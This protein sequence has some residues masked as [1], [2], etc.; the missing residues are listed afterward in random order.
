MIG[1]KSRLFSPILI[2]VGAAIQC[3]HSRRWV[4]MGLRRVGA[5]FLVFLTVIA[6]CGAETSKAV[7]PSFA[8]TP[9]RLMRGNYLVEGLPH[10]FDCHSARDANGNPVRGMEAAR[11][12]LPPEHNTIPL[13]SIVACRTI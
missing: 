7:S 1:E 12:V 3:A 10:C 4:G 6:T 9:K 8:R 2:T 13:P 11:L 5:P